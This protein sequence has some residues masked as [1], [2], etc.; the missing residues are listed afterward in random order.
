MRG[1]LKVP[2]VKIAQIERLKNL[3]FLTVVPEDQKPGV[4]AGMKSSERRDQQTG[5]IL[6]DT[7]MAG[8]SFA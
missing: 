3:V 6:A 7:D 4:Q 1:F 5:R 2:V 8:K